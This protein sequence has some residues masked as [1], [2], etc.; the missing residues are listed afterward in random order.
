MEKN[1]I[2]IFGLDGASFSLLDPWF[3]KGELPNLHILNRKVGMAI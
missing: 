2:F 1:G 3:A